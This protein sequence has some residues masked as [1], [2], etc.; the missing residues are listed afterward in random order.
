MVCT[1]APSGTTAIAALSA[2]TCGL[3]VYVEPCQRL[4]SG[5]WKASATASAAI[6]GA[7]VPGQAVAQADPE[8]ADAVAEHARQA[9]ERAGRRRPGT[10]DRHRASASTAAMNRIGISVA[11]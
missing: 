4:L 7:A 10:A 8:S 11:L 6:I 1:V 9:A 2:A 3:I 5:N